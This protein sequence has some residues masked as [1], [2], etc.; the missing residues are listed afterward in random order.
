MPYKRKYPEALTIRQIERYKTLKIFDDL[1]AAKK[2]WG[3]IG[4]AI[5]TQ[6]D[7]KHD[8]VYSKGIHLVNRTGIYA[9]VQ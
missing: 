4:G 6:V 5:Y 1:D 2:H 8:R 9:V 7:G 3:K